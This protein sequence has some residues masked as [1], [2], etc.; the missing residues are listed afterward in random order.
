[1]KRVFGTVEAI[2]DILYL[3]AA[4]SLG[5]VLL[6]GGGSGCARLTAGAMAIVLAAG[7]AFHLI[8]RIVVI[9]TGREEKLRRAL[10]RGKQITSITMSVFYLLLWHIGVMVFEPDKITYWTAAVYCLAAVR[11]IICLLPQNKWTERYPPVNWGIFR[12]IPFFLMGAA[13]AGL[14]FINRDIY[15]AL[16]PT[17]LAVLLSFLF[18]IPVVLWAHK[19]PKTGIPMLPKSC[20]YLWLLF[21]CT[22]L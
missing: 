5:I 6:V 20:D 2:F 11:I 16:A 10:G 9:N 8:P 19:N 7:D 18:Y 4:F 12:N 1:M 17:W 21:I 15:S 3:A 13:A 22:S 14:F